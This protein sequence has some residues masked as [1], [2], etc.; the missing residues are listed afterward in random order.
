MALVKKT[1]F[2]LKKKISLKNFLKQKKN[3]KINQFFN[4]DFFNFFNFFKKLKILK[5]TFRNKFVEISRF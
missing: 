3:K 1:N 4:F 2:F 5:Q